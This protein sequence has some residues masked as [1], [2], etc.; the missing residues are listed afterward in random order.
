MYQRS[1]IYSKNI[2]RDIV[3]KVYRIYKRFIE[4]SI[5]LYDFQTIDVIKQLPTDA[6]CIDIGVNEGQM[7]RYLYQQ[8][9][10]GYILGIEPIPDL[11]QTVQA[12]YN[13]KIVSIKQIALSDE[14]GE[15]EFYYFKKRKAISGLKSR[16]FGTNAKLGCKTIK[17][18]V[19]RLD[20]IF[21]ESRLDFIKIDVE[22]AEYHVL[23]G[24]YQTLERFRPIIVFES[25]IGGLEYYD[26]D[27][28]DL[29][30]LLSSLGY[31]ISSLSN[32]LHKKTSFN[33]DEFVNNFLKGYDYQY[34]AY[35]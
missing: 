31:Q 20:Q 15:Q 5:P 12:V 21:N 7:L 28:N 29:W 14:A 26:R 6:V 25:G 23:K 17:V 33:K 16:A 22:G 18:Q 1:L 9:H 30:N 8:C 27:P 34:I 19:R 10:K 2:A 32:Y 3:Y 11:A 35:Q 4:T 24:A 13:R